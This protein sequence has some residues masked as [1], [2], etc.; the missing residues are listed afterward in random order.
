[1]SQCLD[2]EMF[3]LND[4]RNIFF[5]FNSNEAQLTAKLQ[6]QLIYVALQQ[7]NDHSPIGIYV[8]ALVGL[9]KI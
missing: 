3:S 5:G 2:E 8:M 4:E 6:P 7:I 9:D 1:M